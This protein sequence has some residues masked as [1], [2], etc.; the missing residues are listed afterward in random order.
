MIPV[1]SYKQ[2]I[3]SP[4]KMEVTSTYYFQM[5][6]AIVLSLII[7]HYYFWNA[8]SLIWDTK[9]LF[10]GSLYYYNNDLQDLL[11]DH[12]GKNG[13]QYKAILMC[14]LYVYLYMKGT[15]KDIGTLLT[16]WLY[17]KPFP[18]AFLCST[19]YTTYHSCLLCLLVVKSS[20]IGSKVIKDSIVSK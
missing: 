7:C 11:F 2:I 5:L 12:S 3:D 6:T 17:I 13:L 16:K 18:H 14:V 9:A 10:G 1:R 19:S 8:N 4:S 20:N 15:W